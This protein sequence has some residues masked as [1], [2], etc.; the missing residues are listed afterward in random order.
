MY[1]VVSEGIVDASM[2]PLL[3]LLVETRHMAV[4]GSVYAI[5]QVSI[6]LAFALGMLS[7]IALMQIEW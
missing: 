1:Y 5:A 7:S 2:M 3:A 6:S 4:Y